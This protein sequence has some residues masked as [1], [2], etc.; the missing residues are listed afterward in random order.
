MRRRSRPRVCRLPGNREQQSQFSEGTA[1]AKLQ[2][3][4]GRAQRRAPVEGT[5]HEQGAAQSRRLLQIQL[6]RRTTR[7]I[8]GR[9]TELRCR[10][11]RQQLRQKNASKDLGPPCCRGRLWQTPVYLISVLDTS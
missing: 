10:S 1:Q 8:S 11:A 9:I 5:V 2:L 6:R 4:Q 7:T 3:N